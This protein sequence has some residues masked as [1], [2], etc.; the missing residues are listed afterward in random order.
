MKNKMTEKIKKAYDL[1]KQIHEGQTRKFTGK[2]YFDEHIV[3]VWEETK[4]YGA[5]EDEEITALL[6]DSVEDHPD[7]I[8]LEE[9]GKEFGPNVSKMVGE[10]TS[11]EMKIKEIGK[12][13]YMKEKLQKISLGGLKVKLADRKCN[14]SDMMTAPEKFRM[15]YYPETRTMMEGLE[16]RELPEAQQK[17][18]DDI[19]Q[20]LDEVKSKFFES[21]KHKMRYI[22]M[23]EM[24]K[25]NN[26]TLDDI[27]NCIDLGGV[28]YSNTVRNLPKN[29]PDEPIH[30]V[31]VDND[32]LITVEIEGRNYEVD[33]KDV[34]KIEYN[35]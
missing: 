17:L 14:I 28:I 30:P 10:L 12:A 33:L 25:Q 2:S 31:S 21:K 32:G 9:I 6:H 11:D 19:N 16:G 26:I 8:T 24:F 23:Y 34:K 20:I 7:K 22:K 5:T 15:K 13:Q 29:N 1:A 3:K 4:R 27:I 35:K 18:A